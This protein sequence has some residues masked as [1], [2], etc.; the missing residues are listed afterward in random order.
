MAQAGDRIRVVPAGGIRAHNARR[1]VRETG[2]KEIHCSALAQAES[3][4]QHRNP[5]VALGTE[6]AEYLCAVT[7]VARVRAVVSA[8]S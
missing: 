5:R 7:E 3:A 8:L 4:M 6:G 1:V 2:A